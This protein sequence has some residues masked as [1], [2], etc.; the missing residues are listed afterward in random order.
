MN[1]NLILESLL[2]ISPNFREILSEID[3]PIA[4]EILKIEGDNIENDISFIDFDEDGIITFAQMKQVKRKIDK[5][6]DYTSTID[7]E[8]LKNDKD[9]NVV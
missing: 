1:Y 9:N 8:F 2:Y 5:Y 6:L 4:N 7:T 3:H